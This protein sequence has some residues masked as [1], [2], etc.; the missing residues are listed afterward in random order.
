MTTRIAV[1]IP[2]Y[3]E[4]ITIEKVVRDFCRVLPDATVYVFDNNST[5]KTS[6]R[7][8]AV[9]AVVVRAP[10]QGKGNVVQQMFEEIDADMYLM[11]DGDDTYPPECAP[12][13]LD[14]L[15]TTHAD[16]VVGVRLAQPDSA[17][18][19]SFHA[20][21][22]RLVAL[23]ISRLFGLSVT[24]AMSG[25]RAFSRDFV[26]TVPIVS[27]GFEVETELTLQ[28]AAKQFHL[29]EVPVP[30]RARP[31]GSF[32]KLN[33]YRDG[34]LVLRLL[35][36]IFKD[37]KPS[38]CFTILT[39][40]LSVASV[41]AGLPAIIDYYTLRYVLHVP[42]AILAAALT[43][44]AMLSL[45]VGLILDTVHRYHNE[46]FKLWRRELRR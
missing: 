27:E 17:A 9:G 33:T 14:T 16:M 30:Y 5:D 18:F 15:T 37:Y 38:L 44:L 35:L 24:D 10:R 26:K 28:A 12:I 7:A 22:N 43:I 29:V 2:C 39:V 21:G 8:S 32:S 1:L 6:E 13:L 20:F 41:L 36:K 19:R 31:P 45:S 46:T 23:L 11:V 4:E 34:V 40:V 25:Y 3:N 42:L